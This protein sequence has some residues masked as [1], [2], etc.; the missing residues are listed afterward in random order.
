MF[1]DPVVIAIGS[2]VIGFFAGLI[3]DSIQRKAE[4][5]KQLRYDAYQKRIAIYEDVVNILSSMTDVEK[6]PMNISERD[7]SR[8]IFECVHELKTLINRLSLLGSDDAVILLYSLISEIQREPEDGPEDMVEAA[9]DAHL[10]AVFT[11]AI[12]GGLINFTKLAR[13]ENDLL[14]RKGILKSKK[15]V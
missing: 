1:K 15:R 10:R 11:N 6:L 9:Y 13:K 3:K 2:A 7:L 5:K 4:S 8:K 14:L 12:C